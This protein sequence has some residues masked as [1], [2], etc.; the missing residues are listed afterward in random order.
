MRV[1]LQRVSRAS[2]TVRGERV[3]KIGHGLLL[4]V[5]VGK[6]DA[7]GEYDRL[8]EKVFHLRV[9]EDEQGKM[10]RS[11]SDVDGEIL[12]VPQFTL[13]GDVRK[14]RRPSWDGAAAPE[15]AEDR[16]EAFAQAL[17]ARGARVQRG[18]FREHMEVELMND[19]PVT[20]WIDAAKL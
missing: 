5:G 14:G 12:V 2:V 8:A 19:G 20:L 11:L 4:L 17:E 13:F 3:A 1:L 7:F 16:L 15:I 10:N 18:A 6:Q 9:F